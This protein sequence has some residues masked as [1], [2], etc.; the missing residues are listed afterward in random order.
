MEYQE[1]RGKTCLK[2]G[3]NNNARIK[4]LCLNCYPN[5]KNELRK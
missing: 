1:N 3:C 2:D 5:N 4:G